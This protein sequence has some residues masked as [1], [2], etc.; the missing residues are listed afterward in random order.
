MDR[1]SFLGTVAASACLGPVACKGV[2][3]GAGEGGGRFFRALAPASAQAEERD[4]L[5][6]AS[7]YKMLENKE[8]QC[9]LCPRK[10]TVGDS[11]RGYCGVR[12]NRGGVYYTLVYER[13][14]SVH[15]DP[16]EKKPLYHYHPGSR[17]FSLAT[18][19]CNMNCKYC[20]NWEISQVRPE[21]VRSHE[22][23]ARECVRQARLSGARSIAY[24]Y[25]EPVV[26][27]EYMRDIA[28]AGR[29]QGVPS[30]MISAGYVEQQ[31]LRDLL[32]LLDAVKIDLKAFSNDFY[33][34]VCRGELGPVLE[35]LRT[36]KGSGVWLELVYL[37]LPTMNDDPAEVAALCQWI[38]SELGP[39]V[40][41]HFTRFHP[42][43]LMKNLPPTP[44]STLERLHGI[45][46]AQGLFFSYVGNVPGHPAEHT[47]CPGCGKLL[48]RRTGY[49]VRTE[50]LKDGK[51]AGCGRA[52]PGVWGA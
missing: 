25:T 5:H 11:E 32:P 30:V 9:L 31:P 12:E 15:T 23:S 26:F 44:V 50:G 42:V 2:E 22:M 16:I 21:Q 13:P 20:Q 39:E 36:I 17:A 52:I 51:C 8:I 14:C 43:Y 1:R 19:G 7:Y 3:R 29:S 24:T 41:I 46:R 47:F 49:N 48:V 18:A 35:T 28:A 34:T 10:C 33:R 45:A 40:P 6:E 27:W 38:R 37:V 4:N